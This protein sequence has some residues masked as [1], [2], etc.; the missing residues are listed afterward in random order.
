MLVKKRG[1]A[2]FNMD[3]HKIMT[4]IEEWLLFETWHLFEEIK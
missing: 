3:V 4:H 1:D 2:F